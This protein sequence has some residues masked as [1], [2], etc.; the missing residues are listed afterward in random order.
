MAVRERRLVTIL[1][2]PGMGKTSLVN[3]IVDRYPS[4][5]GSVRALD[6]AGQWDWGEWPGHG[7]ALKEWLM[8]LKGE[9]E[10]GRRIQGADYHRGLLILD[11]CDRYLGASSFVK[12]GWRDLWL[13]NRH[14]HMD[15]VATAHRPQGVP[16]DLIAS[17]HELWLFAQEEALALEYLWKFPSLQR[18]GL[19]A[20]PAKAGE[21]VRIRPRLQEAVTVKLF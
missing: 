8:E 9:D 4:A 15:I 21:A 1:G 12:D 14:Y 6:P 11:D 13:A 10:Y 18:S 5:A 7:R 2:A 3:R 19:K 16:K 20:L 17:S